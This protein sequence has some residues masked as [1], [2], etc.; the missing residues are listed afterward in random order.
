MLQL[1]LTGDDTQHQTTRLILREARQMAS[2][3]TMRLIRDPNEPGSVL[4]QINP[5]QAPPNH[6]TLAPAEDSEAWLPPEIGSIE[7]LT[8]YTTLSGFEAS[9]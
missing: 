6:P 4:V 9:A 3:E 5:P 2:E 1:Q 8:L 7:S